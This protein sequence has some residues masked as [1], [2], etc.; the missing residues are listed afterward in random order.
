MG[1]HRI[2]RRNLI[3]ARDGVDHGPVLRP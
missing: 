2:S 1:L 3:A